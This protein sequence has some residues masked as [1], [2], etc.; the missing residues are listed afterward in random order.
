MLY[1]PNKDLKE[2]E[3][4]NIGILGMKDLREQ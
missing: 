4:W 3:Y 2:V 1:S